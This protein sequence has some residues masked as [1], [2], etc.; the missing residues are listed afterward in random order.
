MGSASFDKLQEK[1][2]SLP[3]G[4]VSDSVAIENS[5]SDCWHEL[6]G[7]GEEGMHGGKLLRRTEEMR[8]RPPLLTFKLE[9][10]GGTV[11]GSVYA[12]V[13]TW[14]VNIEKKTAQVALTGRRQLRAKDKVVS[15]KPLAEEIGQLILSGATDPRLVWKNDAHKVRVDIKK[16][17]PITNA[18]TT[19][20][21]R[22]RFRV[23]LKNFLGN[24][25]WRM[26]TYNEYEHD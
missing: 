11:L 23:D 12:D 20:S 2:F 9:R 25:G 15:T 7:S 10:H 26:T 13:Q 19:L 18:Q 6:D 5:L 1:L 24:H 4:L 17:I 14:T 21:R 22:K 3:E 16:V 8:W